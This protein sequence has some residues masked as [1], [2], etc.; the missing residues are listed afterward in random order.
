[1]MADSGARGSAAQIKQLSGMRGLMARPDGSIIETPITANFREGLSELQYF[2][3]THGARKGL[4]DTALKTANSGYLTRRLVDVSQDLVITEYDCGTEDGIEMSA[5]IDGGDVVVSLADQVLG[6]TVA[7]DAVSLSDNS[8]VLLKAGTIIDENICSQLDDMDINSIVVRTA[9]KCLSTKGICSLCYGRDLSTSELV[10]TGEA[11]GIVAAQ[12]IGEPGTQLTMRTFHVGGAASQALVSNNIQTKNPG[13]V[14]LSNIKTVC[15]KKG[16]DIVISHSGSL[17]I[18]NEK[19]R[20]NEVYKI[21]YGAL[22]HVK[23]SASVDARQIVSTWEPHTHPIISELEGKI[24]LYDVEDGITAHKLIDPLTGLDNIRIIDERE[25]PASAKGLTPT[26]KLLDSEGKEILIPNTDIPVQ[27]MLPANAILSVTQDAQVYV[28]DVIA[29]I[30]QDSVKTKDI[31][32]G[33]PRVANLFET[34]CSKDSAILAPVAGIIS[35]GKETKEK[36]AY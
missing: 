34:R 19:G 12:S 24:A 3:S 29:R 22:L 20:E 31:T 28:G 6:R 13:K 9:V 36:G 16:D 4:A 1:M 2:T 35:F 23:D 30:S 7:I 26:I 14:K 17:A 32:G 15:N 10:S 18:V 27:Y 8:K 25:R 33:L 5:I 21:P 11:V